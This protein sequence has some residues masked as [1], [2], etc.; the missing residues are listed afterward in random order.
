MEL[1]LHERWSMV[2]MEACSRKNSDL[3]TYFSAPF[4]EDMKPLPDQPTEEVKQKH[5]ANAKVHDEAAAFWKAWLEAD[6]SV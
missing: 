1:N 2:L 4:D 3:E 6:K 5:L